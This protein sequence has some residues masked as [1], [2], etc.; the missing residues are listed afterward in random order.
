[1]RRKA[2][3]GANRRRIAALAGVLLLVGGAGA[4]PVRAADD[5]T[6]VRGQYMFYA[7]GCDSCHTDRSNDGPWLAGGRALETE[8]GRFY[9]PN[10]TPDPETGIGGWSAEQFVRAMTEGVAPD[11]RHYY[12]AFPYTSYTGVREADLFDLKAFLDSVPPVHRENRSHDLSWPFSWRFLL[13]V[14]KLIGFEPGRFE[15][16]PERSA[17]W[18]RGAY[19]ITALGHCSECHTPRGFLGV[20][21][22]DRLFAG[23]PDGSEGEP[24]PNITPDPETGIGEWSERDVVRLLRRGFTPDGDDV[25]GLMAETVD[26]GTRHLTADDLAAM[27]A[28]LASVA[29]IRHRVERKPAPE[30][31]S[32]E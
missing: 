18:N 22:D 4:M 6:I 16:T 25:Q 24:A 19:L 3:P 26:H 20:L 12:P 1:M 21:D 32:P 29:P 27:A 13:G 7:G 14:W 9:T 28:Y 15:P 11:G 31:A 2:A 23:S 30:G 17:E 8:F 10:I 5:E